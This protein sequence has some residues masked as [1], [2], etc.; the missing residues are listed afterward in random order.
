M[1]PCWSRTAPTPATPRPQGLA[2]YADVE[3]ANPPAGKWTAVFFTERDNAMP[4]DLGTSGPIQWDA[5][6]YSFASGDQVAPGSLTIPAGATRTATLDVTSPGQPGDTSES[7]VVSSGST[8]TTVP[9]T[10]RTFVPIGQGG[11]SFQG[12]LTGGNGRAGTEAQSNT[13]VFNVPPG[14]PELQV[15]VALANDPNSEVLG[16]LVDP[17]GQTIGY[18]SNDTLDSGGNPI[19]TDNVN[20][21]ALDPQ[22]GQWELVLAWQNPVSGDELNEP[23]SGTI[24]FAAPHVNAG[25][26]PDG[27][28]HSQLTAGQ[29]YNYNVT[30]RNPGQSPEAFFADPRLN[31]TESVQLT[32]Q[33][34]DDSS[35]T[36]PL[37]A[38]TESITFPYYLVPPQSTEIDANLVGSVPVTFDA[39]TFAGD[40]DLLATTGPGNTASLTISAPYISPGLWLLN[41]DE[42]GPYPSSGAPAATASASF[43]VVTQ[44]FDPDVTSSSGDA[45]TALNGFTS[46]FDPVYVGPGQTATIQV[47]ITP[48]GSGPV[49][50]TLYLDDF[51]LAS[52]FGAALP[53]GQELAAIPY[54]YSVKSLQPQTI[55]FPALSNKRL[56]QSPVTV[57]ATASSHLPVSFSTSTP[58][59]CASSGP[60]GSKIKLLQ[61]GRCTR[62][63]EPGRQ[64]DLRRRAA[65]LAELRRQL[66][67]GIWIL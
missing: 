53:N 11:G 55:D 40:P 31:A 7:V 47:S 16:Y 56:N 28:P 4:G 8:Q 32:D 29:T 35:I 66:S 5:G 3:V 23:F 46:D 67:S 57:S 20:L 22:A 38:P 33:G 43:S 49:S 51:T 26:L 60:N 14:Q 34:G 13:Y 45:W 44:A 52:E 19:G 61:R 62:C 37:A 64:R 9:V 15:G 21:Y 6:T 54:S 12:V 1:S 63:R 24:G 59:V 30:I 41:P 36:L 27:G 50:G 48:S 65:R 58:T 10:V 18:S 39:G 25:G 17:N 42:I 2:D